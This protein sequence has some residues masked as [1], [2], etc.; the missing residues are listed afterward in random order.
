MNLRKQRTHQ[1]GHSNIDFRSKKDEESLKIFQPW[2]VVT[3]PGT[4]GYSGYKPFTHEVKKLL[5]VSKNINEQKN[6]FNEIPDP[7]Y[8]KTAEFYYNN[9]IPIK[10]KTF[11]T[12]ERI[13]QLDES[14]KGKDVFTGD[15]MMISDINKYRKNKTKKRMEDLEHLEKRIYI[16][17][18]REDTREYQKR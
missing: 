6:I 5:E 9:K 4:M 2:K 7:K 14:I 8:H 18:F 17:T 13:A 3:A 10:S 12:N 16:L 1:V 15:S 11:D